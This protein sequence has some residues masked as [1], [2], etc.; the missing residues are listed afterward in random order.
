MLRD[1]DIE[2]F[3]TEGFVRVDD[4]FPRAIAD[5]ARAILWNET[6][7]DP[8][9]R[10]TWTRPVIRLGG[11]AQPPFVK[12]ASTPTICAALDR[13]VGEGRWVPLRGLGTFPIR[14]PSEVSA[15]DDGWHVDVSFALPEDDPNDFMG[16]RANVAS[17]GRALLA[18]FLFSDVGEDDAPTRIRARSHVDLA[19]RLAPAGERGMTLRE[20]AANDFAESATRPEVLATGPAG[21]V[22][23]CHPFL[24]HAAQRHRG[25]TPRFLAQPPVFPKQPLRIDDAASAPVEIAIREALRT[26]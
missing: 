7:C 21:T 1:S 23:L 3:V 2:H 10:T 5:E 13:I 12:A 6:G 16:W 24:V 17:R 9:D 22:Y 19:R 25:T 26:T 18:L 8:N 15:G 14:F 11:Y 4:A 20:L